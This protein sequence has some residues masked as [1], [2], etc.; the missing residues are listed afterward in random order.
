[1]SLL[2]LVGKGGKK[3]KE[4]TAVFHYPGGGRGWG[5][6]HSER[7]GKDPLFSRL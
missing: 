2:D 7:E 4:R 1:M 6:I 3:K 5:D